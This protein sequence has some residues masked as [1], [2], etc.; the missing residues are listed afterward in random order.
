MNEP[1][2]ADESRQPEEQLDHDDSS[3]ESLA[4]VPPTPMTEPNSPGSLVPVLVTAGLGAFALI[5]ML[6]APCAGATRSAKLKWQE[7]QH[8]IE[9]AQVAEVDANRQGPQ[10][11]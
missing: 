5:M 3:S 2:K 1:L 6:P 7:R 11:H 8:Q 9:Q 10:R 4:N